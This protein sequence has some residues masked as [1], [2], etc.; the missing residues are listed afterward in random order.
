VKIPLIKIVWSGLK[1]LIRRQFPQVR[2]ISTAALADW[3]AQVDRPQP[4]LL[5]VRTEPEFAISHLQGAIHIDPDTT[6]F[7]G[8]QPLALDRPIV[9]YCSIGYRSAALSNRLQA[10]GYTHV[11]NLEGSIFQWA[12]EGRSVYQNDRVVQQ[13]HPF[14]KLWGLLLFK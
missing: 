1:L 11:T 14:N 2:H 3:L 12:N 9:P 4:L 6:D 13:V 8:L 10:A 5:D 7:S